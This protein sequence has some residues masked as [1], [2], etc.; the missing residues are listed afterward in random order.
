MDHNIIIIIIL[1]ALTLFSAFFSATETAFSSLNPIKLKSMAAK[2]NKRA[3]KVLLF[4]EKFDQILSTILIGNNIVNMAAASIAT[5]LFTRVFGNAGVSLSTIVMTVVVLIFGEITPKVIAKDMPEQFAMFALPILKFF[6]ILLYPFNYLF[7]LWR[8]LI[9]KIFKAKRG[10]GVTEEELLILV[11]EAQHE[12]EFDAQAGGLI[13]SAIKFNDLDAEEICTPRIDIKAVPEE[14]TAAQISEVFK[15][16][17]FSRIPVYRDSIDDII[18]VINQKDF[19]AHVIEDGRPVASILTPI[20]IILPTVKIS[21]L[22]R[23]FQAKHSHIALIVDEYGGTVGLVT[24]EDILEEL[25]GEIW[26]EHD[27]VK[28]EIEKISEN[29]YQVSGKCNFQKLLD[30]LQMKDD[31]AE[32]DFVSVSGWVL[33]C[34]EHMPKIGDCFQ[35][36]NLTIQIL[37]ATEKSITEVLVRKN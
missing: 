8:K 2:G 13:R 33:N 30:V 34:S 29:E 7:S 27:I 24:L 1:A 11:E 14:A 37:N 19:Y 4:S 12:G 18:G 20:Q 17:G 32:N 21:K 5:V 28:Y 25:V 6:Y 36:Q 26:D 9:A 3:E 31:D 35:Y 10:R 22:M 23:I 16:Y 15:T